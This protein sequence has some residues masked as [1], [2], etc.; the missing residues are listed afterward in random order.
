MVYAVWNIVAE[1]ERIMHLSGWYIRL[2]SLITKMWHAKK[3]I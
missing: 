2:A 3:V 1:I